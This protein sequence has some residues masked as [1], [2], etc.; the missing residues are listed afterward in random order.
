MAGVNNSLNAPF[1][2]SATLGGLGVASPTAHGILVAE[3]GSPATPIVLAAGQVLIGT[4]ALD[5]VP[6][7]LTQGTGITITSASGSITI[8]STISGFAT[9][10]QTGAAVTMAVNTQ[11]VNTGTANAQVTYTIPTTAAQGALFRIIGVTGNNGG[12]I[13]QA[14]TGQTVWVGNVA[15]STAGTWTS[16]DKGDCITIVCTV[17]NTVF[18]AIDVISQDLVW[19]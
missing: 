17:A 5:P 11:Y 13:L 16:A 6:A 3:G 4:T 1:P 2:L 8:A 12:W 15:C 19:A 9:V 14:N 7:T 18:V 10:N